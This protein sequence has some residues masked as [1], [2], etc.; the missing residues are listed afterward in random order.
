MI[1]GKVTIIFL[2]FLS[3]IGFGLIYSPAILCVC[4]Y[5]DRKRAVA[6]GIA[7]CGSGAG[8][9]LFP[10]FMPAVIEHFGW[11]G[12]MLILAGF[13]LQV[14]VAGSLMRTL[15]VRVEKTVVKMRP[16]SGTGAEVH[17]ASAAVRETE[18]LLMNA[19]R[20][21]ASMASREEDGV[22]YVRTRPYSA[23][24]GIDVQSVDEQG[25]WNL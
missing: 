24:D 19:A 4:Y 23:Q 1:F 11:Q 17:P 13:V 22:K 14:C 7:V 6:V 18:T 15:A 25:G 5:F 10:T 12:S 21:H 2:I 3:G 9:L 20:D 16:V 8:A